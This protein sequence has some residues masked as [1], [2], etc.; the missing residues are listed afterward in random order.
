MNDFPVKYKLA[1]LIQ[2]N[3]VLKPSKL[4]NDKRKEN[5]F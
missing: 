5:K 1:K 4:Y 2:E 3:S